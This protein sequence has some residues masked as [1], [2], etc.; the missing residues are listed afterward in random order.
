MAPFVPALQPL[1]CALNKNRNERQKLALLV[2]ASVLLRH[3][4][5]DLKGG[6]VHIRTKIKEQT[7][8]ALSQAY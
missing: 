1:G 4:A 3:Q 5:S 6:L 8:R 2:E 7:N